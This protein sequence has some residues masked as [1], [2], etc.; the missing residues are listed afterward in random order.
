LRAKDGQL[1]KLRV[2]RVGETLCTSERW[3]REF[4]EAL[5]THDPALASSHSVSEIRTPRQ[6]QRASEQAAH[7]L[8]KIGI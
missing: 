4:F 6:R 2:L 3:L 1:L 8:D 5:T 7:Q